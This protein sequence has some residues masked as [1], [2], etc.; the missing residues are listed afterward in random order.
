MRIGFSLVDLALGGAQVCAVQ[1]ACG[2][3]DLGHEIEYFIYSQPIMRHPGSAALL[4]QLGDCAQRVKHP[5]ELLNCDVIQ[6]DGF[7][8]L[9]RKLPYIWRFGI[10]LETLHSDYSIR[11]SGPFYAPYRVTVSHYLQGRLK[12]PSQVIYQGIALPDKPDEHAKNFDLVIV[13][14]IHPVKNHKLFLQVCKDLARMRGNLSV[15][16]LGAYTPDHRY[17]NEIERRIETLK[18][19]NVR[20]HVTGE[21]NP[22]KVYDWISQSKVCLVTSTNEGFGRMAVEAMA[23]SLPVVANP[24]G[25]LVEIVEDGTSGFLAE[26]NNADSF[27]QLANRLLDDAPLRIELGKRG[28]LAAEKRFTIKTMV[29]SYEALYQ[30]I[31]KD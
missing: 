23:C 15:L 29:E 3:S 31:H 26:R 1:L 8:S 2:L 4:S 19:L 17:R 20:I 24:V 16:I 14:R 12:L 28:R 27:A 18:S 13:G 7:H 11:R 9:R 6:L 22:N 25:G 30:Q 21:M 10:C 5:G